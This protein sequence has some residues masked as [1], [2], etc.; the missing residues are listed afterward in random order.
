MKSKILTMKRSLFILAILALVTLYGITALTNKPEVV[1]TDKEFAYSFMVK[2]LEGESFSFDQYKGK[3]VFINLW[4]T[5]CGPCR[6]E[7][8]GIQ[9]LY[10][11]VG[12][13]DIV[14]VMLSVDREGEQRKVASYIAANK[15]TFPVYM[16]SGSLPEQLR[17]PSIPTT[18]IVGRDGTI[19]LHHVGSTNYN[20]E[21]YRNLLQDLAKKK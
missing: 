9:K 8:P 17:V 11:A 19:A 18:F 1:L 14:F 3:V 2:D 20:T 21:K 6:T 10:E 7:M 12:S 5:W 4:A 15:Y 16:P 13:D